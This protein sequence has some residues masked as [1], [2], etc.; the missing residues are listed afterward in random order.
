M[1]ETWMMFSLPEAGLYAMDLAARARDAGL[2]TK[3]TCFGALVEGEQ[4]KVRRFID[5]L[6]R[7]Y[8]VYV[9]RRGFSIEDTEI[10][11]RTFRLET[12]EGFPPW[13]PRY[14]GQMRRY[15]S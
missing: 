2:R 10:C 5:G 4:G 8:P 12:C 14:V 3:E 13:L 15:T 9:K 7:R 11:A 6:R 1:E